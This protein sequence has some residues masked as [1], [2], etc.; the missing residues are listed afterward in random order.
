[1]PS[2]TISHDVLELIRSLKQAAENT[3]D[4][5]LRRILAGAK[6]DRDR[7]LRAYETTDQDTQSTN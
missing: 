2:I 7:R 3:E 4:E 5:T 6:A 1:M